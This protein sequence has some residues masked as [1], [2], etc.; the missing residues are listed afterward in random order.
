[1]VT[2]TLD[3]PG[4]TERER[5]LALLRAR[6]AALRALGIKRLRLFGSLARGEAAPASDVDLLA[7][8]DHCFK[9]SLIDHVRLESDLAKLIGRRVD[10][11][12][13]PWKMHPRMRHRVEQD[14]IEI[15]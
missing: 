10:L 1:M 2:Q 15:F 13:A 9:F 5:V 4:L 8:I 11:A 7:E 3:R 14:A 6:Q 12:T